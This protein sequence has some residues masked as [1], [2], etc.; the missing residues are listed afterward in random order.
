MLRNR[1]VVKKVGKEF[2]LLDFDRFSSEEITELIGLCQKKLDDFKER[3]GEPQS[4]S[5][6]CPKG[7]SP[8][9]S[10]TRF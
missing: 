6:K 7:T 4:G 3:A 10:D 8:V 9:R 2:E 5:T 1:Q